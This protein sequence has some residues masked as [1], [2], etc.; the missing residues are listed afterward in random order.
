[1]EEHL[2]RRFLTDLPDVAAKVVE[3]RVGQ[4]ERRVQ[5]LGLALFLAYIEVLRQQSAEF[6]PAGVGFEQRGDVF[7][8]LVNDLKDE[9]A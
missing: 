2:D 7:T 6:L 3:L 5:G 8:A 1:M 4:L 9:A